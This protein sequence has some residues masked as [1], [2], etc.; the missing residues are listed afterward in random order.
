MPPDVVDTGTV[1]E[2]SVDD[3][4]AKAFEQLS[5]ADNAA[6]QPE[7]KVAAG[8]TGGLAVVDRT[9]T[10]AQRDSAAALSGPT[11]PSGGEG[12]TGAATGTTGTV[13][14]TGSSGE[15]VLPL[16][17]K[18]KKAAVAAEIAA[19]NAATLAA[20]AA[21]TSVVDP[22]ERLADLLQSRQPV[23]ETPVV[24]EQVGVDINKIFTPQE[25]KFL[26]DYEKEYPDIARAE[27]M[28]RR[29]EYMQLS[30]YFF[31]QVSAAIA[32]RL[33]MLEGVLARIHA[34][35]LKQQVPTYDND[36]RQKV[37]DWAGTQPGYLKVAYEHVI[38]QGTVDEVTDLINRYQTATGTVATKAAV[39]DPAQAVNAAAAAAE[40]ERVA[41][42]ARLAPVAA[43]GAG[44]GVTAV[45]PND[46]EG[47]FAWATKLLANS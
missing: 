14:A 32:P 47:G 41:A 8:A 26:G 23:V 20:A 6:N 12:V 3:I 27:F 37:V 33:E 18:A 5:A 24:Q 30:Q 42:A 10:E 13:G 21:K 1:V 11:G 17:D 36:L 38:K 28:R 35:D 15:G 22:M 16:D 7:P 43:K 46:F 2:E 4:F 9:L 29:V 25:I 44:R 45:S 31:S 39:V 19:A 34:G 40:A